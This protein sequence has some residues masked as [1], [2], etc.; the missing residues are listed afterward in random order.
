MSTVTIQYI[1]I[2]KHGIQ[3]C[4]HRAPKHL[5]RIMFHYFF[6]YLLGYGP[7]S[8]KK[9]PILILIHFF[10]HIVLQPV[11]SAPT[12]LIFKAYTHPLIPTQYHHL[13]GSFHDPF[14]K[15]NDGKNWLLPLSIHFPS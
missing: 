11:L 4:L 12:P 2:S 7:L 3:D 6:S 1:H 14:M 15:D 5:F 13:V 9:R 10:G 8:K